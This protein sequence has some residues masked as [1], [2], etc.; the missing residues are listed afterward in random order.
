V[1]YGGVVAIAAAWLIGLAVLVLDVTGRWRR[2]AH[3]RWQGSGLLLGLSV[4][5]LDSLAELSGWPEGQ[6][7]LP[8]RPATA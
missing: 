2:G 1:A 4:V 8:T 5:L 7:H 3:F 6:R